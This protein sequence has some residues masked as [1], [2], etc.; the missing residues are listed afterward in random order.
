MKTLQELRELL[1]AGKIELTAH[2]LKRIVERNISKDEIAEAGSKAE[3]IED[4]PKDKYYPSYLL[5]GFT[6]DNRPLH[7]HVSRMPGEK[8]RLITL[9]EPNPDEW[10]NNFTKRG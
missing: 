4:Y 1:E 7:L 5:L 3:I 2:S 9:Y 10:V 6:H 8:V